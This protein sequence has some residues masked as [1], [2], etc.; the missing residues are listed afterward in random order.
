MFQTPQEVVLERRRDYIILYDIE[1]KRI[2]PRLNNLT[3][4]FFVGYLPKTLDM[5]KKRCFFRSD[6]AQTCFEFEE[7][8][9]SPPSDISLL[10]EERLHHALI[11]ILKNA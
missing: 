5:T 10:K 11:D 8:G 1:K 3:E 9:G 4:A 2:M 7:R 6:S